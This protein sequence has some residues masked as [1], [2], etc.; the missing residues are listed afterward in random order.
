M[1]CLHVTCACPFASTSMSTLTLSLWW[2][3]C[4]RREWVWN[5][6]PAST[7]DSTLKLTLTLTQTDTH[8]LRVNRALQVTSAC[9]F[10]F[11]LCHHVLENAN[12]KCKH[13]H[14]LPKNPFLSCVRDF[15]DTGCKSFYIGVILFAANLFITFITVAIFRINTTFKGLKNV[16]LVKNTSFGN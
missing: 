1:A 5:P 13:N 3:K 14:L 9:A 10:S 4:T 15:R 6:F 12:V 2:R 8:T 16:Y 11:D 7:I